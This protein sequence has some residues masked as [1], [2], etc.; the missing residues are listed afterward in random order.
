MNIQLRKLTKANLV[1]FTKED[2]TD[3]ATYLNEDLREVQNQYRACSERD[4]DKHEVY[5]R[6]IKKI[7]D[8]IDLVWDL[9]AGKLVNR[10]L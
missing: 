5:E 10:Y 8:K 1:D 7:K 4:V 9:V 6:K 2:L 3:L